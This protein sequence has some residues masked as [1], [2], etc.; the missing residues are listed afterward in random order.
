MNQQT[1]ADQPSGILFRHA[2]RTAADSMLLPC[3]H[4][5]ERL[6]ILLKIRKVT[7]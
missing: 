7:S 6:A 1:M 5:P 3:P 4:L 2:L